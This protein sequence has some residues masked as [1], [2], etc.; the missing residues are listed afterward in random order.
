MSLYH[1]S[2]TLTQKE[3][4][5]EEQRISS[6]PIHLRQM[7]IGSEKAHNKTYQV[8]LNVF[9]KNFLPGIEQQRQRC[10][11]LTWQLLQSS[12]MS[13]YPKTP[14]AAAKDCTVDT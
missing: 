9:E 2:F 13:F 1:R 11:G 7:T 5:M 12:R 3:K 4:P 6:L 10:L 8:E 14:N